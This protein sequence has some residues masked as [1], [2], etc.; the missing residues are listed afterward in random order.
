MELTSI[1]LYF[2]YFKSPIFFGG[3]GRE[4]VELHSP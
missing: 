2:F 3:G 4:M 1:D